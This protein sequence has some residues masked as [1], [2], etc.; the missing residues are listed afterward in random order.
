MENENFAAFGNPDGSRAD[1]EEI[2][3]GFINFSGRFVGGLA[4][5]GGLGT[6]EDDRRVRVIVGRKGTGKT[7]YLRRLQAHA[8]RQDAIYADNI[9]Q[10]L[11]PTNAI[12]K[13][14]GWFPSNVLTEQWMLV[15]RR[16]IIRS[17][18][19]HILNQSQL[20]EKTPE[21]L[22]DKLKNNFSSILR[23]FQAPVSIYSQVAELIQM[24]VSSHKVGLVLDD[25]SWP[26]L[27]HVI[28]ECLRSL[29]PLC[30]YIDAIDEELAHAPMY[31]LRCQKGLFYAVMR[32]LRE[33]NNLGG[34]LHI[35]ICIRDVV[36]SSVLRSEHSTRYISEEHIRPLSWTKNPIQHFLLSKI[37][38]LPDEYFILNPTEEGR[39]VRSWLGRATIR[40]VVRQRDE[41]MTE[42]LLR[43]TRML[44]RDVVILGNLLCREITRAKIYQ[45]GE[46]SE[47]AIRQVVSD[48][49]RTFGSEQLAICGNQLLSD[50]MPEKAGVYGYSDAFTYTSGLEY[51]G[52]MGDELGKIISIVGRDRF[53]KLDLRAAE[54]FADAMLENSKSFFQVLWQNG[55]LGYVSKSD[56]VERVVFYSEEHLDQFNLPE[57][58]EYVFH[59]CLIDCVEIQPTGPSVSDTPPVAARA[60]AKKPLNVF[61]SYCHRDGQS[62]DELESHLQLLRRQGEIAMWSDRKIVAGEELSSVID[63]NLERADIVLLLVSSDFLA[64]NYCYDIEMT[65]ALE[66]HNSGHAH[67]IPI[68]VRDCE[69]LTAPFGRLLATPTDGKAVNLWRPR[70]SAW[71]VIIRDIRRAIDALRSR[72]NK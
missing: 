24:G 22:I 55:L 25:P 40:N 72:G 39:T 49:A 48:A 52:S 37:R 19:S 50:T 68:I 32:L 9:Q 45:G 60:N 62:R 36:F 70:D 61:V 30:F 58:D 33:G 18:A 65:K 64:S 43:H 17:V 3:K 6:K 67:V 20:K 71:K 7:V 4:A 16:A 23:N 8:S 29:P 2:L 5:W 14:S 13:F 21:H 66:R 27:E 57:R 44:P 11:P 56:D 63:V 12:V 26:E 10:D 34:R 15:W 35:V 59:A 38:M 69:W 54:E 28:S 42:Y 47:A 31:W 41:D 51:Q 46:L 1:I 53:S